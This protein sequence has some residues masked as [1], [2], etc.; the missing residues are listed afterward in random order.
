MTRSGTFSAIL[1][2]TYNVTYSLKDGYI[3]SDGSLTS[4]TYA[5]E[6]TSNWKKV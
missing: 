3:W 2:G 6:I 4:K 5:W 1:P